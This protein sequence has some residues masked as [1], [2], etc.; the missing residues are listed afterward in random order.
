MSAVNST[1]AANLPENEAGALCGIAD[2]VMYSAT[3]PGFGTGSDL[4]AY[5]YLLAPRFPEDEEALG[6]LSNPSMSKRLFCCR[7]SCMAV[8]TAICYASGCKLLRS[9]ECMLSS[10]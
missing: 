10:G 9:S 1:C 5:M 6:D 8:K 7:W 4:E 2:A 3:E